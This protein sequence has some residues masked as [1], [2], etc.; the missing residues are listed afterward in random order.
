M[1]LYFKLK[2]MAEKTD[3][4]SQ[5]I[6]AELKGIQMYR[7]GHTNL[8]LSVETPLQKAYLGGK[9]KAFERAEDN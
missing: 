3:I 7:D 9:K 8:D 6:F 5:K 2:K 4:E 1:A